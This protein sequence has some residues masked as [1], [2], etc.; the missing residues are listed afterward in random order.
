MPSHDASIELENLRLQ[1][2][3][4]RAESGNAV[5]RDLRHAIIVRISHNIEQFLDAVAPDRRYDAKLGK[6]C[7]DGIDD[8]ILLAHEQMAR[9]MKHQ[10]ALLVCCLGLDEPHVW[11][12]NSFA[13]RFRIGSIVLLPLEIGFHVSRRHQA[14]CVAEC[15][16]LPRPMM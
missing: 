9:A 15:L 6:M 3:Q 5:A 11:P 16:Q 1:H 8:R 10:A 4:L 14:H 12:N 2:P 7:P 13:D